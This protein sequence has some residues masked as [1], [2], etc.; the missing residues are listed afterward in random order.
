MRCPS[1]LHGFLEP[2]PLTQGPVEKPG[3][4]GDHTLERGA[5]QP[6]FFFNIFLKSNFSW[7]E[8]RERDRVRRG[9]F[10]P[11]EERPGGLDWLTLSHQ[12][13]H[14][15]DG[16]C[17]VIACSALVCQSRQGSVT[18]AGSVRL[19]VGGGG[20]NHRETGCFGRR[21]RS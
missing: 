16:I 18:P 8:D 7:P 19:L 3:G 9:E 14:G 6:H 12:Q 20:G 4:W 21:G 15:V 10:G 1:L 13:G 17:M 5:S 2:G 11:Q